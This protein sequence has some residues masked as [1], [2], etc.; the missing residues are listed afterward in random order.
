MLCASSTEKSNN[1]ISNYIFSIS[2]IRHSQS[3]E[4]QI[5]MIVHSHFTVELAPIFLP[6]IYKYNSFIHSKAVVPFSNSTFRRAKK[7][8]HFYLKS[9]A[10]KEN[11]TC[12]LF[13]QI[14]TS[15][16]RLCL[17]FFSFLS[18]F[19]LLFKVYLN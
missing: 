12:I 9:K 11:Y 15:H 16:I 7:R 19:F 17:C 4:F 2:T 14:R 5:P 1:F 8:V 10:K 13:K 6:A 3:L 18:F